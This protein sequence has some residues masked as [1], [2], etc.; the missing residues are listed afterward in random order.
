MNKDTIF[1][2]II[3]ALLVGLFIYIST[4]K[5]EKFEHQDGESCLDPDHPDEWARYLNGVCTPQKI[6][7]GPVEPDY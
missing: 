6:R 5:K 2:V 4:L 3:I 7:N 1:H